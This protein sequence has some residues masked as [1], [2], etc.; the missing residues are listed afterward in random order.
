[1]EM[2]TRRP[3]TAWRAGLMTLL[4][5]VPAGRAVRAP[6]AAPPAPA[7]RGAGR[8]AALTSPLRCPCLAGPGRS[9]PGARRRPERGRRSEHGAGA[10]Q[11]RVPAFLRRGRRA[12]GPVRLS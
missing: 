6:A 10:L 9:A 5:L 11:H 8:A 7:P 4:L 2:M 12:L 3:R 1:M